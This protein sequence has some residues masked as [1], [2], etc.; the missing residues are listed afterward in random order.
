[1]LDLPRPPPSDNMEPVPKN[2]RRCVVPPIRTGIGN[3]GGSL[4]NPTTGYTSSRPPD[5]VVRQKAQ[6]NED[7]RTLNGLVR[8]AAPG[9]GA[10]S[11][12]AQSDRDRLRRK[13]T[14]R[15]MVMVV[16]GDREPDERRRRQG[17]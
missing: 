4:H 9:A 17:R 5:T 13:G 10:K 7:C 12:M 16:R 3:A 2:K 1:M 11:E 8:E 14:H 15:M 6:F